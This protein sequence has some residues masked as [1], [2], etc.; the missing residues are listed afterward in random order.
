MIMGLFLALLAG[1]LVSIQNIFNTKVNEQGGAWATTTLVLGMGFLASLLMNVMFNGRHALQLSHM[2]P[3][4]WISGLIGVGVVICLMQGMKLLGPTYAISIVLTAQLGF[5]LLW[6][7][8]GWL[9][10]VKV[11]FTL[12]QLLGVLIIVGGI[13]VFKFGGVNKS[14]DHPKPL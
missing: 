3:W 2:Q 13:I 12:N 5:A 4:Y 1:A 14:K 9:G 6:D 11:P 7:S 10:L 8:M